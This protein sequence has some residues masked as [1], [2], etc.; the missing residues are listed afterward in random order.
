MEILS[1]TTLI[2]KKESAKS[3]F[4]VDVKETT[5]II[6]RSKNVKSLVY[7]KSVSNFGI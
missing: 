1:D 7:K 5:I 6:K 2:I 3:L 4:M